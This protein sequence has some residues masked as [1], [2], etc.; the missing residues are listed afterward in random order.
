MKEANK[1][2]AVEKALGLSSKMTESVN[3]DALSK[4][5]ADKLEA[6]MGKGIP[7]ATVQE[8]VVVMPNKVWLR[9]VAEALVEVSYAYDNHMPMIPGTDEPRVTVGKLTEYL[10]WV[11]LNRINYLYNGRNAVHPRSVEYPTMMYDALARLTRYDGAK[12]DG[13]L[14]VPKLGDTTLDK[15][16]AEMVGLPGNT[17]SWLKDGKV[18]AFPEH[19]KFAN[20]LKVMGISMATGLPMSRTSGVRTLFE[21]EMDDVRVTTAGSV[22]SIAELFARCYYKLDA[23]SKLVGMQRVEL[24]LV[25]TLNAKIYDI[26]QEYV[27]CYRNSK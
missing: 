18:I 4:V 23:L 19:E 7:L 11:V 14:I 17:K 9:S 13:A 21:M 25:S 24:M 12:V 16:T 5:L 1:N 20:W 10:N 26:A 8:E 15:S 22:P 27:T 6:Y 3:G 2:E